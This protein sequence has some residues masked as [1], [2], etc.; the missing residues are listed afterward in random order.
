MAL[1]PVTLLELE[2]LSVW[3]SVRRPREVNWR[4][5][6][7]SA[8][9]LSIFACIESSVCGLRQVGAVLSRCRG[10]VVGWAGRLPCSVVLPEWLWSHAAVLAPSKW[11]RRAA[12]DLP[13]S[14]RWAD[15]A[16]ALRIATGM[17]LCVRTGSRCSELEPVLR[18]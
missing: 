1:F 6:S 7:F 11:S 2:A 15:L 8:S 18:S 13:W 3:G 14:L 10:R 16:D 9:S 4:S 5:R 17:G 12:G